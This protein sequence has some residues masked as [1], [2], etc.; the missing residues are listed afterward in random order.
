MASRSSDPCT[1]DTTGRRAPGRYA[2]G[3][4]LAA[5]RGLSGAPV[6][7]SA[8]EVEQ[9]ARQSTWFHFEAD[10]EWFRNDIGSDYGIAAL[11]P[12]RRRI[13]VPAQTSLLPGLLQKAPVFTPGMNASQGCSDVHVRADVFAVRC[14]GGRLPRVLRRTTPRNTRA[15]TGVR[16]W[17]RG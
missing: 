7:A 15:T 1:A 3:P 2:D 4:H 16:A 10:A 14:S 12:D 11:S 17:W 5:G 9:Q 8:L 13:A 6:R